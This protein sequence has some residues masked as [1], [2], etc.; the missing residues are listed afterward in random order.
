MGWRTYYDHGSSEDYNFA[1]LVYAQTNT[2]EDPE[3]YT[4]TK[5]SLI[6]GNLS[7]LTADDSNY[8]VVENGIVLVGTDPKV[9]VEISGT[10]STATT[11]LCFEVDARAVANIAQQIQLKNLD[12]GQF[13]TLDYR[14]IGTSDVLLHVS[15]PGDPDKYIGSS[16]E[17]V[18]RLRYFQ[19]GPVLDNGWDASIDLAQ[20]RYMQ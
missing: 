6:S 3:G 11:E 5:G 9:V 15:V 2:E 17:V 20:F 12:S 19:T 18:G 16:G 4:I 13:E 14:A 1:T 8:L 7:S 10:V